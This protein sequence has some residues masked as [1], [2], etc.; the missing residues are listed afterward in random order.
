LFLQLACL[1]YKD[2]WNIIDLNFIQ[3][4]NQEMGN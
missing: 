2:Y 1:V 4:I 3:K